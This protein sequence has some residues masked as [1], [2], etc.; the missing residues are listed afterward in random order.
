MG[1]SSGDTQDYRFGFRTFE[2]RGG[3]FYLNGK[4]VYL[5]GALDQAFYPDTIYTEPSLDDLR[6][7]MR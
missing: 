3:K 5:R 7:E 6:A 4:V 2:T 1:L